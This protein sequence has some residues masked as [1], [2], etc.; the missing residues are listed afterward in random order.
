MPAVIGSEPL[1]ASRVVFDDIATGAQI[2]NQLPRRLQVPIAVEIIDKTPSLLVGHPVGTR[3][4]LIIQIND[5]G[6]I[7]PWLRWKGI[8]HKHS[9]EMGNLE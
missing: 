8:S 9:A 6:L 3:P 4:I 2:R 7:G 5:G 1:K